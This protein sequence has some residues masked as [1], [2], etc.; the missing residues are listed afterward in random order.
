MSEEKSPSNLDVARSEAAQARKDFAEYTRDG[1]IAY[2]T[3][4]GLKANEANEYLDHVIDDLSV[5]KRGEWIKKRMRVPMGIPPLQL[6]PLF[7]VLDALVSH[8][9]D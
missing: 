2:L 9:D 7:N 3:G 4:R 5:Y 1:M 8:S 6:T